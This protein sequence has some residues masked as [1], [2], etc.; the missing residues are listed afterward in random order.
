MSQLTSGTKKPRYSTS[1]RSRRPSRARRARPSKPVA[2]RRRTTLLIVGL[3]ILALIFCW[4][5]GRGCG[6][7]QQAKENELLREYTTAA[8]KVISRSA[9][10]GNQFDN[11]RKGIDDLTRD[12]ISR[13]LTK[14][15]DECKAIADDAKKIDVPSKAE[16]LQPLLQVSLDMRTSGVD[17]YRA[18]IL[19]VLDGKEPENSAAQMSDGLMDLVVSDHSTKSF[20]GDLESKLKAANISFEKVSDSVFVPNLDD[21]LTASVVSYIGKLSGS[22]ATGDEVHGVAIS[23]LTTSPARVD[24]T[25]SGV[26]ILPHAETFTVKVTVENQG[27][28]VEEDIPVV[29]TLDIDPEGTPQKKTQKITRLKAGETATLVFEDLEPAT[30]SD[31]VN[32]MEV[33]AGPVEDEKNL[34][35]NE[36]ELRFIMRSEG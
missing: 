29:V 21:A 1:S 25:E 19:N 26:S 4:I 18:S 36:S 17:K 3:G 8:N 6:G 15:V 33:K 35:N 23:G 20:K 31:K 9:D 24:A 5:F 2:A 10:V 30:G 14:M 27:N 34:E 13:K 32:I 28:Q 12:E 7:N 11:L 16:T 22:E